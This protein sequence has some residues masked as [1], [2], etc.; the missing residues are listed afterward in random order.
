[1]KPIYPSYGALARPA[2]M[3]GIPVTAFA[4]VFLSAT[5]LTLI[6]FVLFGAKALF[7]LFL[8]A[9]VLLLFR[10]LCATDD[11][12]LNVIGFELLCFFKKRNAKY[13]NNTFTIVSEKQENLNDT[14]KFFKRS[15]KHDSD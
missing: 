4:I 12:A 3:M 14:M 6:S 15:K 10:T 2:M 9:P 8:C 7:L 11:Q 1:M 5:M 13:F